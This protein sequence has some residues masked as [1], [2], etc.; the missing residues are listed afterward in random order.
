MSGNMF[1]VGDRVRIKPEY[2]RESY[3]NVASGTIVGFQKTKSNQWCR[4]QFSNSVY[5]YEDYAAW[6]LERVG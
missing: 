6:R 5:D 3:N 2:K 4:V 1:K